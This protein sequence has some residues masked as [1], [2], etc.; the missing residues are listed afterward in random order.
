V[1][2]DSLNLQTYSCK[3]SRGSSLHYIEAEGTL[4]QKQ[5]S[6]QKLIEHSH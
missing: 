3:H 4:P 1:Q 2:V 6:L 5:V